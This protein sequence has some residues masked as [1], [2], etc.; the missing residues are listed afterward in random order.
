MSDNYPRML[1]LVREP[2]GLDDATPTAC[3][4]RTDHD[5]D[6]VGLG[7]LLT[8]IAGGDRDAFTELYRRTSHRVYGLSL[9]ILNNRATAEEVTQ[10]VYLQAW[11]LSERYDRGLASPMGWLM[12][13]TH[14]RAID[15]MR[16]DIAGRTRETQYGRTHLERDRDVVT[17]SVELRADRRAVLRCLD[18]LTELQRESIALAYYGGLSYSEVAERLES[19][20]ATVKARIREGLKRLGTCLTGSDPR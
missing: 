20:L 18:V 10:E 15:R 6:A 11:S 14:R 2:A 19:P 5:R 7:E 9:R 13:L 3:P 12:M 8:A 1:R 16:A 4:V 17:E